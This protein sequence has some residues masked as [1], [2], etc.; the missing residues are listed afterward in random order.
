[1]GWLLARQKILP[2]AEG[3][4]GPKVTEN[5]RGQQQG[6]IKFADTVKG[7]KKEKRKKRM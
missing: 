6:F 3:Q 7:S 2:T 1:V 5:N 4:A